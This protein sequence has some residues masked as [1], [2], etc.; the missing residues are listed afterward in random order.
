MAGE[1]CKMA[2]RGRKKA[3][4]HLEL[5]DHASHVAEH[6][7]SDHYPVSDPTVAAA[8]FHEPQSAATTTSAIRGKAAVRSSQSPNGTMPAL[9]LEST[10]T[11]SAL[12]LVQMFGKETDS[13]HV[14]TITVAA[15][16]ITALTTAAPTATGLP[17]AATTDRDAQESRA[18]TQDHQE[19]PSDDAWKAAVIIVCTLTALSVAVFFIFRLWKKRQSRQ[20]AGAQRI[21]DDNERDVATR[22]RVRAN[23]YAT[24]PPTP[25]RPSGSAAG[26]DS[27]KGPSY[28]PSFW[29]PQRNHPNSHVFPDFPPPTGLPRSLS[30]H[31]RPPP[32]AFGATS[33]TGNM[34]YADALRTGQECSAAQTQSTIVASDEG[35]SP[36]A[37]GQ[38]K[39]HDDA[40]PTQQ[41]QERAATSCSTVANDASIVTS[42]TAADES[43]FF[44]YNDQGFY[45]SPVQ[46][47]F[48]QS[49][50]VD[51]Q[52]QQ[53]SSQHA[54]QGS[55]NTV[56]TYTT[57]PA[58][59]SLAACHGLKR[60][61]VGDD[62]IPAVAAGPGP[63]VFHGGDQDA[64][65]DADAD[66]S[67]DDKAEAE[68]QSQPPAKKPRLEGEAGPDHRDVSGK[69][70]PSALSHHGS[71][72]SRAPTPCP[73]CF[74]P[75]G[76]SSSPDSPRAP[77]VPSGRIG[78]PVHA[79]ARP[80]TTTGASMPATPVSR[81][82]TPV[83]HARVCSF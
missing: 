47:R 49:R 36:Y 25:F 24:R 69:K 42:A 66:A 77:A 54:P 64:T 62:G 39:M 34:S 44:P 18:A 6:L 55:T 28:D 20:K 71:V 78:T 15:D 5:H 51:V 48:P 50:A 79:R 56:A 1:G 29:S 60:H 41:A 46:K 26:T 75:G 80:A 58:G 76:S 83:P 33:A 52:Q 14:V 57:A 38:H 8:L 27:L 7:Q 59:N 81:P 30:T 35:I 31:G 22:P 3:A 13:V 73:G 45:V 74:V 11:P 68:V 17:G 2:G 32:E 67:D 21:D 82:G 9:S 65:A 19:K 23:S 16:E 37:P 4:R 53:Q 12:G 10:S 61:S 63:F 43:S 40:F 70:S 72:S